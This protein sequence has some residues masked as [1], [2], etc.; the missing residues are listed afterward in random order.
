MEQPPGYVAQG[1]TKICRVKKTIH[2]LKQSPRVWLEKF[3]L[4]IS[5][6]SFPRSHSDHYVFVRHTRAGIVVLTVYIDDML[7]T[8]SDSA[9]IVETDVSQASFCD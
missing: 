6:I 1:E 2:G 5:G 8:G 4:I 7:L 9:G 3:S